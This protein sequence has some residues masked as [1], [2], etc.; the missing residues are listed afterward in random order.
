MRRLVLKK[1]VLTQLSA[2]ELGSVVA[3]VPQAATAGAQL[4]DVLSLPPQAGCGSPSCNQY[5]TG[6]S[7]IDKV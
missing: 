4:C 5:C 1:E 3:G 6:R 2:D 7:S